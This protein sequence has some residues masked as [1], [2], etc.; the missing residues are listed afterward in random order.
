MPVAAPKPA[1]QYFKQDDDVFEPAPAP[2]TIKH[3]KAAKPVETTTRGAKLVIQHIDLNK[4]DASAAPTE[5]VQ[6]SH[7]SEPIAITTTESEVAAT[8]PSRIVIIRRK[9]EDMIE[10][11][12]VNEQTLEQ[13]VSAA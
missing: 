3:V 13:E 12:L 2:S 11:P 6:T 7:L 5:A 1:A 4:S 9:A 10:V 8:E